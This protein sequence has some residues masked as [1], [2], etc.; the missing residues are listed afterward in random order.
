[1]GL[2]H[3]HGQALPGLPQA[4]P[5][6]G[7]DRRDSPARRRG[8]RTGWDSVWLE[9]ISRACSNGRNLRFIWTVGFIKHN[10]T[11]SLLFSSVEIN[12]ARGFSRH[13]IL[14]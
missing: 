14:Q 4:A 6:Q 1:M 11:H 5:D 13:S 9:R 10:A 3:V 2:L 8:P 7:R 12:F